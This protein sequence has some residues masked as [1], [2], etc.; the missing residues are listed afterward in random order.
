VTDLYLHHTLDGGEIDIIADLFVLSDGLETAVYIS[1]FGG[2]EED[3]GKAS[4]DHLQW[5]GNLIESDPDRILRSETQYLLND[6]PATTGNLVLIEE[7]AVRDLD[8]LKKF[9]AESITA[10][11][12][13]P[14]RN[15]IDLEIVFVIRDEEQRF[16]FPRPW[17][18]T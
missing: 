6:I 7:A 9:G 15:W 1:L 8:W 12:R 18:W 11:A 16:N 17:T 2:N 14:R 5:W 3:S 4:D 13:M 10:T